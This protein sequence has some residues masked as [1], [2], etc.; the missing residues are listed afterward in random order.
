MPVF[1]AALI[2][3]LVQAAGTL[4]GR[5]LLSLGFGYVAYTGLSASL[6]FVKAQIASSFTGFAAQ[7]LAVLSSLNAG[8]GCSVLISALGVRLLLD[9]LSSGGAIK[10]L[11]LK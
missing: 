2:G 4:V 3:G 1:I 10:K 5:V 11:V 9:G 7:S 8:A 6:D